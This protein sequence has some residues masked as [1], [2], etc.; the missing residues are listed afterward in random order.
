LQEDY[1]FHYLNDRRMKPLTFIFSLIIT[2]W[3]SVPLPTNAQVNVTQEHN[4][5]SRDGLYID[6]VFTASAAAS[7]VRDLNFDRMIS[8]NVYAQPL[9]VEGGP[10][11]AMII[12]VTESI[13][14]TRST[15][16]T[17][18]LFGSGTLVR[19][20]HQACRAAT[21]ARS[22]LVAR[23]LSILPPDHFS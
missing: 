13:M 21:S 1:G 15:P 2:V 12:A 5:L 6:S 8:G 23:P 17:E 19:Q 18:P 16:T 20:L 10:N 22:V 7:L 11:G 9:Y 14:C 3:L 4:H